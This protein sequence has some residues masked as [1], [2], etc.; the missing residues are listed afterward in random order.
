VPS[1]DPPFLNVTVPVGVPSVEV[2]VAVK[3]T[4]VSYVDGFTDEAT[5][6]VVLPSM[7]KVTVLGLSTLPALSVLWNVTVLLPRADTVNGA[8]YVVNAPP[9]IW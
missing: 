6:V 4:A 5:E 3:V 1:V 9:L 7:V 2:T 8:V